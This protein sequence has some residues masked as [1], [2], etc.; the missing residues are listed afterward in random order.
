[1]NDAQREKNENRIC[2]VIRQF[3]KPNPSFPNDIDLDYGTLQKQC[4]NIGGL[5]SV[6]QQM[7]KKKM[8]D[9]GDKGFFKENSIITLIGDYEA[10]ANPTLITYDEIKEKVKGTESSHTKTGG[11]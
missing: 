3:G 10:Q 7:K 11:W 4:N 5:A 1:M 6:L 2:E 9:F 8:V